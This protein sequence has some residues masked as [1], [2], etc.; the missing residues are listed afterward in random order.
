MV[1]LSFNQRGYLVGIKRKLLLDLY[2]ALQLARLN[3]FWMQQISKFVMQKKMFFLFPSRN[4]LYY[5]FT[6]QQIFLG[7]SWY[8]AC[9][10]FYVAL[11]ILWYYNLY[12]F[13][14]SIFYRNRIVYLIKQ[15]MIYLL[16]YVSR[17]RTYAYTYGHAILNCC[18]DYYLDWRLLVVWTFEDLVHF[19]HISEANYRTIACCVF[20]YL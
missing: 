6:S 4:F 20:Q 8:A 5:L 16:L 14:S 1:V 15:L 9:Y 7:I 18:F 17:M 3:K 11:H 10:L 19:F 13:D 2:R 12:C